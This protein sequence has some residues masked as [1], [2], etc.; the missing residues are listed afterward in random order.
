M[1]V[2]GDGWQQNE[3]QKKQAKKVKCLQPISSEI[4]PCAGELRQPVMKIIL[5]F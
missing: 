2:E 4:L 5:V 3:Q 1:E